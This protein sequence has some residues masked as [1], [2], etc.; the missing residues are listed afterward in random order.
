MLCAM[1]LQTGW[2]A[3]SFS[4]EVFF[5]GPGLNSNTTRLFCGGSRRFHDWCLHTFRRR[6]VDLSAASRFSASAFSQADA[7]QASE[8]PSQAGNHTRRAGRA[9]ACTSHSGTLGSITASSFKRFSSASVI[10]A[11][12]L[13]HLIGPVLAGHYYSIAPAQPWRTEPAQN[14]SEQ[15][16]KRARPCTPVA[17]SFI[18]SSSSYGRD[19]KLNIFTW[20]GPSEGFYIPEGLPSLHPVPASCPPG[21]L[22][23]PVCFPSAISPA[24]LQV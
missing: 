6:L 8:G 4:Q 1:S 19:L 21:S 23:L 11:A 10:R 9:L 17:L 16:E 2:W 15:P 3:K 24:P 13:S 7:K 14:H 12:V 20:R 22:F 18:Q 5:P